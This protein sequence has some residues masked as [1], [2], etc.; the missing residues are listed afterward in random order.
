MGMR[1]RWALADMAWWIW[2]SCKRPLGVGCVARSVPHWADP[3]RSRR[4]EI[5]RYD[6]GR[7][8]YFESPDGHW[9]EV[10]TRPYGRET[11]EMSV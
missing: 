6:G 8:F 5:N 4:N 2:G 11:E 9:L 1:P 10:I 7:G 3:Y